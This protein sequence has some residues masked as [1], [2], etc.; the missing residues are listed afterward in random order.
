MR[1]ALP[2]TDTIEKLFTRKYLVLL[3]T[4]IIQFHENFFITARQKLVFH[5]PHV[6][7]LGTHNC[8][9]ELRGEFKRWLA[10]KDVLCRHDY[11][12]RV[13]SSLPH[14]IQS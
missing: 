10:L 13:V 9:I 12:E 11:D 1:S 4:Y 14:Q 8:G 3:E 7:I 2:K 5:F 6:R